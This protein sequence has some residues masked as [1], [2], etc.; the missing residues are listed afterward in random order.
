MDFNIYDIPG[1]FSAGQKRSL[2]KKKV[3]L[4]N[5]LMLFVQ[6]QEFYIIRVRQSLRL[7]A[8]LTQN[9][10]YIRHVSSDTSTRT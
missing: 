10:A 6:L 5:G 3:R 2:A 9:I 8:A 1:V 7:S 4:K